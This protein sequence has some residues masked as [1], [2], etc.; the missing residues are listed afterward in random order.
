MNEPGWRH[1]WLRRFSLA[2]I[3]LALALGALA[4][5]GAPVLASI[6]AQAPP[7]V[8]IVVLDAQTLAPI[9]NFKWIINLD[10]SH[11]AAS[12]TN[13]ET[14]SPVVATGNQGDATGIELDPTVAPNRGYLVTV[15]ATHQT[16]DPG[17]PDYKIGGTHFR[18]PEDAGDI[19][20]LLEPNELPLA[21]VRVRVFHDNLPINTYPDVGEEGLEGFHITLADRVGEVTTDWFGNPICTDYYPPGVPPLFL[22]VDP[23][24]SDYGVDSEGSYVPIPG[25]GG[26]CATGPDGYVSIPNLGPNKFEVQGVPPD[27]SGWIQV[28]TIE[29]T[30]VID[31]WVEENATG[32]STEAGFT[33]PLVWLGY[34]R[35]CRFGRA[36]LPTP[37]GDDCTSPTANTSGTGRIIG[38]VRTNTLDNDAGIIRLGNVVKRPYIGLTNIGGD[39]EQVWTGRGTITGTFEI[40]NVPAGLYQLAVW[41]FPLDHIIQFLTVQVGPGETVNMGDVG[42]PRWFSHIRGSV[43][44]DQNQN[45]VR[46]PGE[47]GFPTQDLDTRFKEGTI[48]YTAFSDRNGNYEFPE[49][50]ELEHFTIAEVGYGRFKNTG[51]AAYAAD[52][53][54][55][56]INYPWVNDCTDIDGNPVSPCTP[57]SPARECTDAGDWR[58][59]ERGPINQDLGLAGLLQAS[60]S[61]GGLT[62]Y[63]DW[64]KKPFAPG[65]NGGIVGIVFYATTRNELE[66]RLQA[67]EDYEAGVPG[68]TVNL[69]AAKL[70]GGKVVTDS[71]TGEVV[72]DHLAN[73]YVTDSWFDARPTDCI[74]TPSIGRDP[75]Q[76]QPYPQIW[77]DCLEVPSVLN[78]LR[79][80][81]FDGGYAFEEDCTDPAGLAITNPNGDADGD[82]TPNKFDPDLLATDCVPVPAGKWIVEAVPPP[83]YQ[84]VKEEDINV[85]SGDT[86]LPQSAFM[87]QIPPPPCAG[88]LHTVDVV[89]D[90]DDANF[91]PDSPWNTQGVYNPD[92]LGTTSP[93]ALSGGSPY[94]GQRM[95]LCNRRLIDLKNGFNANSDFFI[96]TAVPAPGRIRGLLVDNLVL[97]INPSSALYAEKRGIPNAPIGIRDFTGRLIT[98]VYSDENGYW[99]VLLPSTGS[100]NC[101]VPAGPCPGM[102]QVVG[103]DPGTPQNP[104]VG[105]NPNY[106]GLRLVFDIWPGLTTY[107]DVAILPT[108]GFVQ[109]AN[110]QFQ[111]AP[112]C[113]IPATTPSILAVSQPY[114]PSP[115]AGTLTITGTGF[116]TLTGTLTLGGTPITTTQWTSTTIQIEMVQLS[117]VSP[118]PRQLLVTGS[119]GA[120]SPSGITF[121]RLGAGYNPPML[122][123][124]VN[125][126]TPGGDGSPANPFNTLQQA[127]TTT[128]DGALILVRP[129]VYFESVIMDERVKLQ[130]YGPGASVIDGRFFNFGGISADDFA[131]LIAVTPYSGPLEVPMGQVV[132]VLAQDGEFTPVAG[133]NAQID[134]FA[135]RSGTRVRGNNLVASQG[136]AVYAHAYAR[137]LEISNNLIQGNAGIQGGGIIFG[138]AFVTNPNEGG[139]R[140]NQNDSVRIHHNRVLNN[141]GA[142]LAGAIAL[143]NG[144]QDFDIGFNEI[145]GNYSAEYGAGISNWGFSSGSIHDN[146]ILFNYAFDEGGGIMIAGE[147]DNPRVVSPGT[148][149]IDIERNLI[150]GN[151]S[152]DDGGGVRLLQPVN[153]R[154]R[155]VNNMIVNNLATDAGGG[156]SLDDALDV[157]IVN[158]TVARNISTATAEDADR[159]SCNPVPG[160]TCAHGA[161]LTSEPHSQALIDAF[162]PPTNFSNP[163]MFNNIFWRNDAYYLDGTI[164]ITGGGL[165]LSGTIDLEVLPPAT[166][167]FTARFSDCTALSV[168][169]PSQAQFGNISAD[170]LFTQEITTTFSALAF[171]GDPS[172]ITVL[173][174]STPGDPQGDYHLTANAPPVDQGTSGIGANSAPSDDF[175]GQARPQGLGFDMGA[176]ETTGP[177]PPPILFLSLG[178]NGTAGIVAAA[179]EDILSFNGVGFA[180]VFDGSDVGVPAAA[181]IDAFAIISPT[182]ILLSFENPVTSL[183][184]IPGAFGTIDDSDVVRFDGTLGDATLGTFS[185]FFDGSDPT[186]GL[187]TND[188]DV[189][190]IELLS[191]NQ[192]VVSTVG[193]FS[194]TGASGA[195]HDLIR[196]TG[197]FGET[198]T[199][200]WVTY[201]DG[202][203]VGLAAPGENIDGTA[204]AANSNIYLST[205]GNFSVPGGTPV[206]TGAD[207]DVFVCGAPTVLDPTACTWSSTLFFDGSAF[208]L[209]ANDLD[210][211]DLP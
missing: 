121:H 118:G 63:I 34:V 111:T 1:S 203:D 90:P 155:I 97:E 46:D 83:G 182:R 117:L 57:G 75:T 119:N 80:G 183:P 17:D 92:F 94:E 170:P 125:D 181:D 107:A 41:D 51:A 180:M 24:G 120:T 100:Y 110:T 25:T 134:G 189:D 150:Q 36:D 23:A 211:I 10:N 70:V 153:G 7:S 177:P 26:F 145:C 79:P 87:P 48:Q 78:Q 174:F 53:F 114:S 144:T 60:I 191:A 113:S 127:L 105:W 188:E 29:G 199:C 30:Q 19:E 194:V 88:P 21:T 196:C 76:V 208:G 204:V 200:A 163:L 158:N 156:I 47:P 40:P 38:R 22:D 31:G 206:V 13:P 73:V 147:Q 207:E 136:G 44:I 141:G 101:P 133:F 175:D 14:Y 198:T 61:W 50:F 173:I 4:L 95:P 130:G 99:E 148:G 190:A 202:D 67:N 184:G 5:L 122:F 137:N 54:G 192:L 112:I 162:A 149:N 165:P 116:G 33:L 138:Q 68:V 18:M 2:V 3:L 39:D 108:T 102:Y 124:D 12:T 74:P 35:E 172:F 11:D 28:S 91:D 195:N 131:A 8:N 65:E 164:A 128:V 166:G 66:A 9:P 96:F 186:V 154:V 16:G 205:T 146:R 58:T 210:A 185:V 15:L 132:T 193:A 109:G 59:C 201:F 135:I 167:N 6:L 115:L 89:D 104:N 32:F 45:G 93:L 161:G 64:G 169:C 123:V 81:V 98:T 168:H 179:D 71:V 27:G 55:N 171:A 152:N 56:P 62:N 160:A 209:G 103:N 176:D 140:D 197:S 72:R 126:P 43:Y 49:V 142:V 42:I 143:F 178:D 77:D 139:A 84:V 85:F 151:V 129:G 82:G 20:V 37:G 86:F 52:E 187:T 159:T 69:Y 106:G 157:R